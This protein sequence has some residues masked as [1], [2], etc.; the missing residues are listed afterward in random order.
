MK[1]TLATLFLIVS[2]VNI[3]GMKK[4]KKFFKEI[5]GSSQHSEDQSKELLKKI[6]TH[7]KAQPKK[8]ASK[9]L[10]HSINTSH[11]NIKLDDG[12]NEKILEML[13]EYGVS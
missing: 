5:I 13:E 3:Y 6:S 1:R 12:G 4:A 9:L 8:L 10:D 7:S 11:T 2:S